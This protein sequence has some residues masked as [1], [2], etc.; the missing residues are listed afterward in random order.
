MS[1]PIVA[2]VVDGGVVQDVRTDIKELTVRIIDHDDV[3]FTDQVI[4]STI[5]NLDEFTREEFDIEDSADIT[6]YQR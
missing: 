2:I 3:Q 5:D 4:K 1:K 6:T